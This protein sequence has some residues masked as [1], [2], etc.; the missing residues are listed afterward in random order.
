MILDTDPKEEP[1]LSL[2][3]VGQIL[4][5]HGAIVRRGALVRMDAYTDVQYL[6][7]EIYPE[8]LAWALDVDLTSY[9][10]EGIF[11]AESS[12]ALVFVS[13]NDGSFVSMY[14]R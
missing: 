12:M 2:R 3:D 6:A 9:D 7:P 4:N 13:A 5:D 14:E 1:G 11:D 10:G 8:V